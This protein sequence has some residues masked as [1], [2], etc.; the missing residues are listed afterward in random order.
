LFWLFAQSLPEAGAQSAVP[1]KSEVSFINDVAPILRD[2]CFACHDAKKKKG[3]LDMTTF[4]SLRKGGSHDDPV[5]AGNPEDSAMIGF[6]TGPDDRRMPPKDAGAPLAKAKVDVIRQWI[7]DGAK[8][9]AS[10]DPKADLFREL[11][12]RWQPPA[13]PGVYKVP[14]AVTA[15]AFTPDKKSLV[16]SGYHELT[17][18][19]IDTAKL[20]KR[21]RTRAERAYAMIFL[22]NGKLIVAGGRPGQEGDVRVYNL[23]A[24]TGKTADGVTLLDGVQDKNVLL[25]HLVDCDDS[26][27]ALVISQDGKHLATAGCDR[28]IRLWDISGGIAAARLDQTVANHADWVLG[29]AFSADGRY[30]FSTSRDNSAKIW[31]MQA[32]NSTATF[33]GHQNVVYGVASLSNSPQA[34][35]VGEDGALRF[36]QTQD[37]EKEVV[38]DGKVNKQIKPAGQQIK[39]GKGGHAKAVL[40]LIVRDD[41][42]KPLVATSSADGS[43]KLW[44]LATG[45]ATKT[46]PGLTDYVYALTISPDGALIAAGS[47]NGEVR[48]W[49]AS[50]GRLVAS[51]TASPGLSAKRQ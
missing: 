22:P 26:V 30:L 42:Q 19:D 24:K 15:L 14:I 4:E 46:L 2:N 1:A 44:D 3:K 6:L 40:Q 18:W 41:L 17:V 25:H 45:A 5:E 28:L 11:R 9:D 12:V 32:K 33:L 48:I 13:P 50:D 43:V 49:D 27:L 21:L 34:I 23:D 36:W 31:D 37:Q 35:S 7:K 29:L 8:L 51:F 20:V 38:K 10:V 16:V 39:V 47:W